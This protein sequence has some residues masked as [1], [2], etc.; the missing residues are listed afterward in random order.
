MADGFGE[1]GHW[2]RDGAWGEL[3]ESDRAALRPLPSGPLSCVTWLVRPCDKWGEAAVG[4]RSYGAGPELAG[5]DVAVGLGA[6]EVTIA[7]QGTGGLVARHRRRLGGGVTVEAGPVAELRLLGRRPGA[8]RESRVRSALPAGA[9]ECLD[10]LDRASLSR[11]VTMLL[12]CFNL[13]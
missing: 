2:R 3:L 5:A 11:S 9:V 1:R 12:F 6:R 8:W 7:G 10:G 13:M 4:A